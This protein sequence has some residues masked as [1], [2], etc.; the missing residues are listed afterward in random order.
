MSSHKEEKSRRKSQVTTDLLQSK[1]KAKKAKRRKR[2]K[3]VAEALSTT[4]DSKHRGRSPDTLPNSEPKSEPA[5]TGNT[6]WCQ[7][8]RCTAM[9]SEIESVCCREVPKCNDL[10]TGEMT[11]IVDNDQFH[12]LCLNS[13]GEDIPPR[14]LGDTQDSRGQGNYN[15]HVKWRHA[16]Y[17]V[18]TS[19]VHRFLG[20][21]TRR[22][23]PACVVRSIRNAYPDPPEYYTGFIMA[24]H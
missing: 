14:I 18:F 17:R 24:R 11:C 1:I 5:R 8:G 7:C 19:W 21:K 23:I 15:R 20:T 10:I 6:E 2:A 13:A 4:E 12:V 16:A 22:P 3:D 9:P